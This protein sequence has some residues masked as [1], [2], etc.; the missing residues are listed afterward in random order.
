MKVFNSQC[1][2]AQ[3]KKGEQL[4]SMML[5]IKKAFNLMGDDIVEIS[6]ENDGLKNKNRSYDEKWLEESKAKLLK[7]VDDEKRANIILSRMKSRGI[8]SSNWHI[9]L[10]KKY[11]KVNLITS[12]LKAINY[13]N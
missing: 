4:V 8:N 2:S 9:I 11:G 5:A 1:L 3:A 13:K 10:L 6:T 12:F 7:Q